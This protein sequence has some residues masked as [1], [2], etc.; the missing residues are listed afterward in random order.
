[1]SNGNVVIVGAARTP[2]GKYTNHP[3]HIFD[4]FINYLYFW[5]RFTLW[6]VYV[7][8]INLSGTLNGSLS[9]LKAH[10]LGSAAITGALI[11]SNVRPEEVSDVIMGQVSF[12]CEQPW[13]TCF[14]HWFLTNN[15]NA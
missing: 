14:K 11:R 6:F 12:L 10:E 1:M 8:L 7:A 2:I 15:I 4:F 3:N 9:S 5:I 13:H